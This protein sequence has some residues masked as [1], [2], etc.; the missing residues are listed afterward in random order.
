MARQE[1]SGWSL[2]SFLDHEE[3]RLG[4]ESLYRGATR[5]RRDRVDQFILHTK[6]NTVSS[7]R[8]SGG[9]DINLASNYFELIAKPNWRLMQYR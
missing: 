5:G 4:A 7:K 3:K 9:T 6:P 2:Q 1:V 8:G